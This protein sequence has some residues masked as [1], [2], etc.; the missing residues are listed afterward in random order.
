MKEP[1][2]ASTVSISFL[3]QAQHQHRGRGSNQ[4]SSLEDTLKCPTFADNFITSIYFGTFA[5][6]NNNEL[7]H[8]CLGDDLP[9]EKERERVAYHKSQEAA[10]DLERGDMVSKDGNGYGLTG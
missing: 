8:Y 1:R 10:D 6:D 3:L 5:L 2:A 4:L 9:V 7:N